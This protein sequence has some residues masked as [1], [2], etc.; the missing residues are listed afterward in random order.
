MIAHY[1]IV[2]ARVSILQTGDFEAPGIHAGEHSPQAAVT[3]CGAE[4]ARVA[5]EQ[6]DESDQRRPK[7]DQGN[8]GDPDPDGPQCAEH[9][10]MI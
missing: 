7:Q 9:I 10:L 4:V 8:V 3:A 5:V 2:A 1:N 6:A